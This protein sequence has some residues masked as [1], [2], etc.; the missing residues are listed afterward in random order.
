[1]NKLSDLEATITYHSASTSKIEAHLL[2]SGRICNSSHASYLR[3]I[4]DILKEGD[5]NTC[6]L[7]MRDVT[8]LNTSGI[9]CLE[10]ICKKNDFIKQ[11]IGLDE[12]LTSIVRKA[13]SALLKLL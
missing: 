9:K 7:D 6:V 5:T 2:L 8:F 11:I 3:M 13:K 12:F 10:K 4:V 1:M